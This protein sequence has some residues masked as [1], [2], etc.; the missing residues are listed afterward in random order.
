MSRIRVMNVITGLGLGGAETALTQLVQGLDRDRIEASVV[1]LQPESVLAQP[2]RTAGIP[3]HTLEMTGPSHLPVAVM[4]LRGLIREMRPHVVQTWLYHADLL[5]S[6][7]LLGMNQPPALAWNLRC[8]AMAME[9]YSLASQLVRW[10]CCL[11]SSRPALVI[12]NSQAGLDAHTALG[13]RPRRT[14]L[15][16]N[17]FDLDRFRPAPEARAALRREWGIADHTTIIGLVARWDPQ[18]DHATFVRAAAL[19]AAQR[20]DVAFVLAGVGL[21]ENAPGIGD[22]LTRFPVA[23]PVRLLGARSDIPYVLAGLDIGGLCSA[24]GEGFPNAVGE[25]MA[26]GLPCV[27]TAVG[28]SARLVG[29][30]GRV[31]PPRDAEALAAAWSE[32]VSLGSERRAQLGETARNRI[33]NHYGLATII[34]RY[35]SCWTGLIQGDQP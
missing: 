31:V 13:Y 20:Q 9:H 35:E 6:L 14:E 27:V 16:P 11:L 8:S 5:G 1:S 10:S 7:A 19:L 30:T 4:R 21:E 15:I 33:V 18:K 34:A 2:I 32:L 24:F 3:L 22:L 17:G 28:D 26:C 12:A 29:E 23:A 25:A